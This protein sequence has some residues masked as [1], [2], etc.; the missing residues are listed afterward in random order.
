MAIPQSRLMTQ[1]MPCLEAAP[2]YE[3]HLPV[4]ARDARPG[5]EIVSYTSDGE[6]TTKTPNAG[7]KV[8]KNLPGARECYVVSAEKCPKLYDAVEDLGDGWTRCTPKGRVLAIEITP[9]V[10]ERL[11]V[12]A[13]FRI[14]APA[15]SK[16]KRPIRQVWPVSGD[17]EIIARSAGMRGRGEGRGRL[18]HTGA[19]ADT[20]AVRLNLQVRPTARSAG[21]LHG[22]HG[23]RRQTAGDSDHQNA[24]G[25]GARHLLAPRP[26]LRSRG[27]ETESRSRWHAG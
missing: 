11:G 5:D 16:N 15:D 13:E 9:E 21:H 17:G 27:T 24:R 22:A 14:E 6:E 7:D 26:A 19:F 2:A 10:C 23:R 8:L 1:I 4:H 20:F 3:K 12:D 18:T 25:A